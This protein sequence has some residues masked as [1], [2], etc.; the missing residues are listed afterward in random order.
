MPRAGPLVPAGF[1]LLRDEGTRVL[2]DGTLLVGGAPVRVLRLSPVGA[3]L[4]AG[5]W[6][7]EP[8]PSAPGARALARRLLDAGLAQPS[9]A[10]GGAGFTERD[11]TVVV[12]ARD[13]AAKLAQ[14][15]TGL[16]DLDP[17]RV[18]VV[19]DGSADPTAVANV[20]S[21]AG[22]RLVRRALNGGPGAA[23]N[24]GMT[25]TRTPL[26]AFVDSDCVPRPGWL[27][28][29]LAHFA[30]PAVGAVAPRIVAH[31]PGRDWLSRYEAAR[32]P[33]DMG[34]RAANVAAGTRVPYV[35]TAA[36]VVRAT[37]FGEGFTEELRAGEDVDFVWRL[38]TA[39]WR[40]RYEP[41]VSVAHQHR[42]RLRPWFRRRMH[43]G[44]SA[45]VLE[46]RHP[47]SVRPLYLSRWTALAWAAALARRPSAA[48]AVTAV[49][50][51]LLARRMSC[52]TGERWPLPT[53]GG[54]RT[55]WPLAA[56]L[57]AGGTVSAAR[58]VG[59]AISR[60]WWPVVLPAAVVLRRSR[61]P[62]VALVLVPPV[63]D[64]LADRPP[65]DPARYVAARLLDDL[66]YSLGVWRGCARHRTVRPLI[67]RRRAAGAGGSAAEPTREAVGD[68]HVGP[69]KV[70]D[71]A[72]P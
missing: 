29:L 52:V 48:V 20:V 67:P 37:A 70:R 39:G 65:L 58:P 49:A 54:R 50:T 40:V 30:D 19:D 32:S 10:P 7:G 22:V 6:A 28:P 44:T 24:T 43:Y 18:V 13:R 47:G 53:P 63:L 5:W 72:V 21:A 17:D 68:D 14:C 36:L 64:W 57:A 66:T 34:A 45:A 12:P 31:Q 8:V 51:A 33:L 2:G 46:L 56:R 4:V 26:V 16:G 60:G 11:V 27:A 9:V 41:A 35:P 15:L 1:R 59:S 42:R 55:A 71:G 62:L 61:V 25:L 69:G 3:K 23:R 38:G